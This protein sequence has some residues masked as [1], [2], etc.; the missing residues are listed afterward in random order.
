MKC[1][2][3]KLDFDKAYDLVSWGLFEARFYRKRGFAL[4]EEVRFQIASRLVCFCAR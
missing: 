4:S 3:L 1:Q 2:V